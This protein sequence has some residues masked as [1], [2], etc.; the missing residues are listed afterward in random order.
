MGLLLRRGRWIRPALG[1]ETEGADA[2][3]ATPE[4]A[5][6]HCH[7]NGAA[8]ADPARHQTPS[9]IGSEQPLTPNGGCGVLVLVVDWHR[10]PA[11]W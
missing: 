1:P 4:S 3:V 9:V 2:Q 10:E 6:T 5:R 8:N 7:H 11:R